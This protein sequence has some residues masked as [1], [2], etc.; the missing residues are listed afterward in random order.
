MKFKNTTSNSIILINEQT[1]FNLKSVTETATVYSIEFQVDLN[2]AA[3]RN[4]AF[5]GKIYFSKV[6]KQ[7]PQPI[8]SKDRNGDIANLI[9][10]QPK[11]RNLDGTQNLSIGNDISIGNQTLID[12]IRNISTNKKQVI[13]R[14]DQNI[15]KTVN[16]S[17]YDYASRESIEQAKANNYS[18]EEKILTSTVVADIKNQPVFERLPVGQ[19]ESAGRIG[20]LSQTLTNE[21]I[22]REMRGAI[23]QNTDPAS[24]IR[25]TG[26]IV[27]AVRSLGGVSTTPQTIPV[28]AIASPIGLIQQTLTAPTSLTKDSPIS[29][30][31]FLTKTATITTS[32]VVVTLDFTID[33]SVLAGV[34]TIYFEIEMF[35]NIF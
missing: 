34:S 13:Q 5:G 17:L 2:E 26:G 16:F 6:A 11:Q 25:K 9:P 12:E 32:R 35:E 21:T 1:A 4:N 7:T 19:P 14:N 28:G 29:S 10:Q 24:L 23:V 15:L 20:Q 8:F 18:R 31:S 27:S 30:T 22:T 3:K 33:T